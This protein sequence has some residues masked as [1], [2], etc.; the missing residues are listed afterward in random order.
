MSTA[1][2]PSL[3]ETLSGLTPRKTPHP[4]RPALDELAAFAAGLAPHRITS[5]CPGPDDARELADEVLLLC[6]KVDRVVLAYGDYAAEHFHGIEL[7]LFKNQLLDALEGN[8]LYVL[9]SAGER[10]QEDLREY[11]GPEP[12]WWNR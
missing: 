4:L 6:A 10:A 11:E 2:E 12:K 7:K 3:F 9:T 5:N 8:A 1:T